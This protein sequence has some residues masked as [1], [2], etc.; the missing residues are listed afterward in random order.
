M[1][2]RKTLVNVYFDCDSKK[3]AIARFLKKNKF[4]YENSRYYGLTKYKD[5]Y[6][7]E[8]CFIVATGPSLT[9]EDI[10]LIKNEYSFSMNSIIKW[11]D[12]TDWRPTFYGVQDYAV[13]RSLKQDIEKYGWDN[14]WIGSNLASRFKLHSGNI[15]PIDFGNHIKNLDDFNIRFSDDIVME[16]YDGY[17]IVYSLIQIAVYMGF[18]KIYILGADCDYKGSKKHAVEHNVPIS[19]D[20]LKNSSERL[21]FMY[22]N[23]KKECEKRNVEIFNATRG[24]KLEVLE[25]VRLEDVI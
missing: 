22:E 14:V 24:G 18:S 23:A 15:F 1:N 13:Y 11:F 16:I 8:R 21:F 9:I 10:E 25:R 2:I 20:A 7:G 12:K 4:V 17:T 5:K 19:E 3:N 6:K